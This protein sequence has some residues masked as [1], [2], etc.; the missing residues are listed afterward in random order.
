MKTLMAII[1]AAMLSYGCATTSG[2]QMTAVDVTR[3]TASL[4]RLDDNYDRVRASVA[5]DPVLLPLVK[6]VDIIRDDIRQLVDGSGGVAMVLLR[7]SSARQMLDNATLLVA[8]ARTLIG[9]QMPGYTPEKQALLL[10]YDAD[11]KLAG[12]AL[13]SALS[14]P[15]MTDITQS[16]TDVLTIAAKVAVVAL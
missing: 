7:V 11:L 9:P 6:R 10:A 5:S 16:L 1:L 15:G 3:L 4:I 2:N 14:Q 8:D 12:A 13:R